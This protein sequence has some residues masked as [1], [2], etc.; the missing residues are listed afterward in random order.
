MVEHQIMQYNDRIDRSKVERYGKK[1]SWIGFYTYAGLIADNAKL[2][3]DN[4]RLSEVDIDPSFPEL[5][6][7]IPISIPNWTQPTI[8]QDE[9]WIKEGKIEIPDDLL[10]KT[11]IE[12]HPGPW[13]ATYGFLTTNKQALGRRVIG[14]LSAVLVSK[15]NVNTVHSLK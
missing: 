3:Q 1:Y 11:N 8:L 10:Y 13:I 12:S 9:L 15:R 5:P 2:P 4:E 14:F 7:P 6:P